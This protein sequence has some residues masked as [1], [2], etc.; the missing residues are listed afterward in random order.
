MCFH[1]AEYNE[2]L[3]LITGYHHKNTTIPTGGTESEALF[4]TPLQEGETRPSHFPDQAER[5]NTE[6]KIAC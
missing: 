6:N 1:C 3:I 4:Y 5:S 2:I